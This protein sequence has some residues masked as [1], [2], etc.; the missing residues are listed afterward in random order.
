MLFT[1]TERGT[2]L[3]EGKGYHRDGTIA[4]FEPEEIEMP[5]GGAVTIGSIRFEDLDI[6]GNMVAGDK[7]VINVAARAGSDNSELTHGDLTESDVEISVSGNPYHI[8]NTQIEYRFDKHAIDGKEINL[9]GY[10]VHPENGSLDIGVDTGMI[11]MNLSPS[12][13]TSGLRTLDSQEARLE[14]NYQGR[15][16]HY[17]GA[18]IN[19]YYFQNLDEN[20][21]LQTVIEGIAYHPL[22]SYNGTALFEVVSIEPDKVIIRGQAHLYDVEREYTYVQ[23]DYIVIPREDKAL[24][25]FETSDFEGLIFDQFQF[26]NLER[27]SSGDRFTLTLSANAEIAGENF[28]E[29]F[30]FSEEYP[31]TV[32]P[33]GWRFRDGAID[34]RST[35]VKTFQI[36]PW[37]DPA[38]GAIREGSVY[39]GQMTLAFEDFHGGSV[40]GNPGSKLVPRNIEET[41]RFDSVYRRNSDSGTANRFSYLADSAEFYDSNGDFLLD[42]PQ[43]IHLYVGQRTRSVWLNAHDTFQ[44]VLDRINRILYEDFSQKEEISEDLRSKFATFTD[45]ESLTAAHSGPMG[46]FSLQSAVAGK[47]GDIYVSGNAS[48]LK[49]LGLHN[50]KESRER[51]IAMSVTDVNTGTVIHKNLIGT[52]N[53]PIQIGDDARLQI[54]IDANHGDAKRDYNDVDKTFSFGTEFVDPLYLR[55]SERD[56]KI[57]AGSDSNQ[58]IAFQMANMDTQALGLSDVSVLN[59]QKAQNVI[60]S[61]DRAITKVSNQRAILGTLQNRLEKTINNLGVTA[62]NITEAESRVRDADMAKETIGYAKQQLLVQT[63][64][65]MLAQANQIPRNVLQLLEK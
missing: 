46:T 40:F 25:I 34:N 38:S 18:L 51:E 39:E 28:D 26:G 63:A 27:L 47:E 48:I 15:F 32:Y 33:M 12:G 54:K 35:E 19:D 52:T 29:L 65:S 5:Q 59:P 64:N 24:T 36:A 41:A 53:K 21:A 13:F 16:D 30:L 10:F 58:Y 7:F 6:G 44:D 45:Q 55:I 61:V 57:Q 56:Q 37:R 50:L 1:L 22:S 31:G 60:E 62:E 8:R 11:V 17:A 20:E 9:L 42:Q 43:Q 23:D 3:V 49:A 4:D 14:V 2:L